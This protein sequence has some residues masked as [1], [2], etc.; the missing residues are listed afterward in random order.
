INAFTARSPML[1]VRLRNLLLH[2]PD[3][4]VDARLYFDPKG[5]VYPPLGP[6]PNPDGISNSFGEA[7]LNLTCLAPGEHTLWIIPKRTTDEPVGHWTATGPEMTRIFRGMRIQF[8]VG[9]QNNVTDAS[10]HSSTMNNGTLVA[11]T[12]NPK[13]PVFD[14]RLRPLWI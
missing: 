6:Q 14:V 4:V 10:V 11:Q 13:D 3:S 5:K 9:N 8:T 2:W 1:I 12:T 7:R